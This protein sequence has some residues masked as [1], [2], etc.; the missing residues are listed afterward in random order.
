MDNF[1]RIMQLAINAK[2]FEFKKLSIIHC[3]II[4]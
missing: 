4:H 2:A 1:L 3:L